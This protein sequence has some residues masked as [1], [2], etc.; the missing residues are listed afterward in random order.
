M[1]EED[2]IDYEP[3]DDEEEPVVGESHRL[4]DWA[5]EPTIEALKQDFENSKPYHDEQVAKINHWTDVLL[6]RGNQQPKRI[7]GQSSVQP[8]LARKQAEWRYSPL[9]EPFLSSHRLFTVE[10]RTF[11][12]GDAARQNQLI[13]NYQFDTKLN[14]VKF[15]DDYVRSVVD[16]GTVFVR[17]G[18]NRETTTQETEVPVYS[19]YPVNEP[20]V[21][22]QLAQMQQLKQANPR[23]FEETVPPEFKASIEYFEETGQ[24]AIAQAVGSEV[25]EEE[26][27]LANHPTVEVLNPANVFVDPSCNGDFDKALFAIV[28][29]E[30]NKADLQKAGIYHN[31]DK[32]N[33]EGNGPDTD[34]DRTTSTPTDY[35]FSDKARKKVVAYEYW[36]FYDI[37]GTGEL[38]PIVA[39]WIGST[40]VRMELN[41]FPDQKIPIVVVPYSP[42]KR[43][44]YGQPDAELIE[45]NQKIAGAVTRGM[46]DLLGKSANSQKGIAK[47]ML[48][49]LNRK[50]FEAGDDYEFNPSMNPANGVIEHKYPEIPQSALLMV[51][52]QHQEAESLTG[53][54]AFSGGLAGD[55]Y[56]TNVATAIRGVLDASSKR[57]MSILRR[58][59]KGIMEIGN[60]I[61]AMNSEFLSEEETIRITNRQFVQIKREDL[62]GNFDLVVDISTAEMDNAKATDLGFMLQTMGP[63]LDPMISLKILASIA[64]LKRMPELAE[65]LRTY[66]PQPDPLAE[67]AKKLEVEKLRMEVEKLRS[68][69]VKN[70]AM[71]GKASAEADGKVLDNIQEQT[72][73]KHARDMEK[74]QAQARGNQN[75]EIVKALTKAKKEGERDPDIEAAIGFNAITDRLDGI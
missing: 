44:L 26:V 65:E 57:E 28:S 30:T 67:E 16:E 51:Q 45:D 4:T 41:P 29:F 8:K 32:V 74:Q 12:D 68:E 38:V 27:I 37:Y 58:L 70:Q 49:P 18:W 13:L 60:K 71:A 52:M 50:R 23:S 72:G 73:V 34:S 75:L 40:L 48:D 3:M 61:I 11:E 2:F 62:K 47:G 14:K 63:N 1:K 64:D 20:E 55:A 7:K 22:Q 9:S 31:L 46:I 35:N 24:W 33:W 17:L 10:P 69:V 59:A 6:V 25:V 56:N 15:I 54:K 53:V 39:T 19:Y 36:G 5:N 42:V 21:L 43:D 66:K